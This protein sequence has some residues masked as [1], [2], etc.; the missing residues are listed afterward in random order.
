MQ[1]QL[2]PMPTIVPLG[3]RT[4]L[5]RFGDTLDDTANEAA[6]DLART[7]EAAAIPGVLEIVSNLISVLVRYD[8]HQIRFHQLAG[9]IRL[10]MSKPRDGLASGRTSTISVRYG[11]EDGPDLDEVCIS[12]G[13]DRQAFIGAH[14][15]Q[16]LRVLAIGFA[17]GFIYC[18][19]HEPSLVVPRRE[20]VRTLV[21]AGSILFATGQTAIAATP[22][23]TG[24]SVIGR[25]GF[26]NFDPSSNPPTRLGAG[27]LLSFEP[28]Q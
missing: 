2:P 9:E 8:A 26:I 1:I 21:P 7:M 18:G 5:V 19:M 3:D 27:D 16:P 10:L 22:L 23:P 14:S 4:L 13:V 24:W 25:T 15:A 28:V 11:G 17:P 6:I 12:L 20:A